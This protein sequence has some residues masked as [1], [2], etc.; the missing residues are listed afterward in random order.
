MKHIVHLL[1]SS[2][3]EIFYISSVSVG[4]SFNSLVEDELW[5]QLRLTHGKLLLQFYVSWT[6]IG[7]ETI[8]SICV[9]CTKLEILSIFVVHSLHSC[10]KNSYSKYLVPRLNLVLV[11]LNL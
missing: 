4:L 8:H 2:P 1:S 6:L 5:T 11:Y 3:F 9:E 7:W 10:W